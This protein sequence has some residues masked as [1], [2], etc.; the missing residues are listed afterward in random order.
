MAKTNLNYPDLCFKK[1]WLA[2]VH[3]VEH[4]NVLKTG[5]DLFI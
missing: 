4:K 5:D 1:K 3:G 2:R